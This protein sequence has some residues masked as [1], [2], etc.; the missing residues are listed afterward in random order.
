MGRRLFTGGRPSLGTGSEPG[1]SPEPRLGNEPPHSVKTQPICTE[2]VFSLLKSMFGD[3]QMSTLADV[4]RAALMLRY[5]NG[6]T[7]G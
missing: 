2:R 3:Q 4:I 6:R 7:L 5:I 1:V